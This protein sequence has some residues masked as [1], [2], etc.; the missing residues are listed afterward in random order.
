MGLK[1]RIKEAIVN[2]YPGTLTNNQLAIRLD[3]NE[4]SVR[5]VTGQLANENAIVEDDG[6]YSG[7]P[8]QFKATET[9]GAAA[10]AAR[11]A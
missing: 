4:P 1:S 6:G 5:R 2:E 7:L 10:A 8:I 3:L 9:D 11:E